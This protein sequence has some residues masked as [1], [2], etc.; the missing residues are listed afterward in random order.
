MKTGKALVNEFEQYIVD[1]IESDGAL[2][3]RIYRPIVENYARKKLGGIYDTEKAIKGVMPLVVMGIKKHTPAAEQYYGRK[4]D[5]VLKPGILLRQHIAVELVAGMQGEINDLVREKSKGKPVG[6]Y[7]GYP[8]FQN[9]GSALRK[10][11]KGNPRIYPCPTCKRPNKLTAQDK[12]RGYQCD[13]CADR[14]EGCGCY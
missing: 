8:Q 6:K 10:A 13:A 3:K 14:A 11:T 4:F 12:A 2:Y 1:S 5:G 9:P 7:G